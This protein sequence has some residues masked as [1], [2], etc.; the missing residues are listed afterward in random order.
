MQVIFYFVQ[1]KKSQLLR[2]TVFSSS[3]SKT[4]IFSF[5][6]LQL[7]LLPATYSTLGTEITMQ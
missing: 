7:L 3:F 4:L 1:K 5:L 6:F 2:N